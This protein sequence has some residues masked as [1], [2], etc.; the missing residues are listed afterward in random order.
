MKKSSIEALA[1]AWAQI[2]TEVNFPTDYAGTASPGVH[3][4][5]QN[6]EIWM[7]EHIIATG[8][9]RLFSLAHLLGQAALRMEQVLWPEDYERMA[10]EIEDAILEAKLE[11]K[12]AKKKL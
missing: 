11:E 5:S 10:N 3:Q 12:R 1:A 7:R 4:A 9:R 2:A 8:D 6:I